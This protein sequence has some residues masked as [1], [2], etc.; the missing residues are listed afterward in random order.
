MGASYALA[1]SGID[2]LGTGLYR[3][4][5]TVGI[6]TRGYNGRSTDYIAGVSF[7]K[8]VNDLFNVQ[9]IEA[10]GALRDWSGAAGGLNRDGCKR[11]GRRPIGG[12][13]EA[14]GLGVAVD[15]GQQLLWTFRF[16]SSQGTP[17]ERGQIKWVRNVLGSD[18]T[19]HSAG[20]RGLVDARVQRV[21]M[22]VQQ[23]PE[24]MVLM[25]FGAGIGA[26][27]LHRRKR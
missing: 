7:R 16:D 15:A 14:A 20:A 3:Y 22:R 6:D 19:Y 25:L 24:P 8:V 21:D 26:T 4:T 5:L 2:N 9:L 17:N 13:A 23:V 12:C 11:G 10:P 1:V 18:G 27:L